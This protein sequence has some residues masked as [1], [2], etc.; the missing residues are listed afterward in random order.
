MMLLL[1]F[2]ECHDSSLPY[3][4]NLPHVNCICHAGMGLALHFFRKKIFWEETP[5]S[6]FFHR[7]QSHNDTAHL[8]M[9]HCPRSISTSSSPLH[10]KHLL[11][12][13]SWNF[14]HQPTLILGPEPVNVLQFDQ[15][16]VTALIH[17]LLLAKSI[18]PF[19][20]LSN[21]RLFGIGISLTLLVL[22]IINVNVYLASVNNSLYPMCSLHLTV[23][24]TMQQMMTTHVL[25]AVGML[26]SLVL[27]REFQW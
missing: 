23:Y 27:V 15:A 7:G 5:Q 8:A 24:T 9:H 19:I 17:L 4:S 14:S 2:G 16:V 20:T 21:F 26:T 13:H 18:P 25:A 3:S 11:K 12:P 1:S 10:I 6:S 22:S